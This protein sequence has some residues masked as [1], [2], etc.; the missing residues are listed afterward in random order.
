MGKLESICRALLVDDQEAMRLLLAQ[1][2][3]QDFRAEIALAGTCE[4]ALRLASRNVYDIILLD[5]MMPGMGGF[6]LLSRIRSDSPNKSTPV[7]IVS[8]LGGDGVSV[9]RVKTLGADAVVSKPVRRRALIAAVRA[10]L[11][12]SV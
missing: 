2:I 11:R 7:V 8:A 9:E 4:A 3:R 1:F 5:L 6:E 12:A 10:Q